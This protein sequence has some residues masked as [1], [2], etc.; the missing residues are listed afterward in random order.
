MF[1]RTAKPISIVSERTVGKGTINA[2][3]KQLQESVKYVRHTRKQKNE[4]VTYC[5][6]AYE[7]KQTPLC[8]SCF[9][10]EFLH[11][12]CVAETLHF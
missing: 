8:K 11:D 12:G 9:Q 3:K 6:S 4:D 7:N 1:E 10:K 5:T 2:G